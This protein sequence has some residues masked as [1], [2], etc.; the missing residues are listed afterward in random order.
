MREGVGF[1]EEGFDE[2]WEESRGWG[3]MAGQC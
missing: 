1:G 2:G 3:W